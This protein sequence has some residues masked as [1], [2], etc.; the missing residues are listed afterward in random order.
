MS[1]VEHC[2]GVDP[3]IDGSVPG[4]LHLARPKDKIRIV[5]DAYLQGKTMRRRL[6]HYWQHIIMLIPAAPNT[7]AM[8]ITMLVCFPACVLGAGQYAI[9]QYCKANGLE[10][11]FV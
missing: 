6:A 9:L 7:K 8:R 4:L 5:L 3:I 1:A 11:C 10:W 2:S